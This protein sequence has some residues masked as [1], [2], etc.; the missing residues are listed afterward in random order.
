MMETK[1][2]HTSLSLNELVAAMQYLPVG[3]TIVESSLTLRYW[4]E[5]FC[6]LLDFPAELMRSGVTMRD[7]FRFNAERGEYGIGDV[8]TQV[9]E[10][11]T[12]ARKFQPHQFVRT[13]PNGTVLEITGRVIYNDQGEMTGFVT[14]Y[15]DLTV[16]KLQEQQVKAANKELVLAY[17][18][19]KRAKSGSIVS[20]TDQLKHYRMA[21]RDPLTGL[22]NRYYLED[23]ADLVMRMYEH[24][25]AL[26]VSL[27]VFDV[28]GFADVQKQFGH[29]G[30]EVVMRR[31]GG[32]LAE[33]TH[34]YRLATR[35]SD[36]RFA[37]F[38]ADTDA[39]ECMHYAARVQ[40][41]V[42]AIRFEKTM[43]SLLV[44]VSASLVERRD[45]E[46]CAQLLARLD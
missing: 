44:S 22:F 6:R 31:I 4:N 45:G 2:S 14:L 29:V 30:G 1:D 17:D 23:A 20:E 18:D 35:C 37:V 25:Q 16:E 9:N 26:R 10:R 36:G 8:D 3:V 41:A 42:A 32:I 46:T 13:R 19:L 24:N 27:L 28:D 12:L 43:A 34:R 33:N 21:M 15:R 7:V 38:V 40:Q 11:L 5:A 39:D